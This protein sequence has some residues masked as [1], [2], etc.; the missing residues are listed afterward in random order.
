MLS[1]TKH[2]KIKRASPHDG[3]VDITDLKSVGSSSLASS[4]LAAGTT[5]K[6]L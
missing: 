3:M 2:D 1:T 4:S 6:V 5:Y